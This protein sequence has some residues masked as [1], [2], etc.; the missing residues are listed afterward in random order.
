MKLNKVKHSVIVKL[1]VCY[2][3]EDYAPNFQVY[4]SHRQWLRMLIKTK[5]GLSSH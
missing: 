4:R 2:P 3:P 5:A 1:L